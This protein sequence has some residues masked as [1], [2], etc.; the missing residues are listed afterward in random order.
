MNQEQAVLDAVQRRYAGTPRY[1]LGEMRVAESKPF[2]SSTLY[3][4]RFP[5]TDGS[6]KTV[7][8]TRPA[9]GA[10]PSVLEDA[11]ALVGF[12]GSKDAS[13]GGWVAR[14]LS[15][16]PIEVT[17]ALIA[18]MLV[19]T[20]AFVV[21]YG[22]MHDPTKIEVPAF[23]ANAFTTVIGFFF[24]RASAKPDARHREAGAA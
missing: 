11:E 5:R 17:A 12:V 4:V 21:A 20:I 24:G 8:V 18:V 15:L 9:G 19:A 2:L 16:D 14:L 1:K 13:R 3:V 22:E 23:L 10:S 6:L 7:Y